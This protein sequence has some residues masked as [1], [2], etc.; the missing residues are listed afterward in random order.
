[1]SGRQRDGSYE[2]TATKGLYWHQP[3]AARGCVCA[4]LL[5]LYAHHLNASG[6]V[7]LADRG[8]F[9]HLAGLTESEILESLRTL[10]RG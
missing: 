10:R 9:L 4:S 1:M 6:A 2:L 3:T 5:D 8:N 7:L